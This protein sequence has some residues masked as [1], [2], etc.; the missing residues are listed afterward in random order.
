MS[1]HKN[2]VLISYFGCM[3]QYLNI[4]IYKS[5]TLRHAPVLDTHTQVHVT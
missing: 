1:I 5:L 2:S 4:Q 3:S